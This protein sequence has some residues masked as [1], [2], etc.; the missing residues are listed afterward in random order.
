V[1]ENPGAT[2]DEGGYYRSME[3]RFDI[4]PEHIGR[5][6][7]QQ[8]RVHDRLKAAHTAYDT[9]RQCKEWAAYRLA[10]ERKQEVA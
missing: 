5:C 7:P 2:R 8:Y 10:A 9:I 4:A 3:G 1:H 6:Y